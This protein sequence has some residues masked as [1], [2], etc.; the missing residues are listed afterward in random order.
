LATSDGPAWT[1][2]RGAES[3]EQFRGVPQ[4]STALPQRHHGE[5]TPGSDDKDAPP[6]AV[7]WT[8][9]SAVASPRRQGTP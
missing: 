1:R 2:E 7:P 5:A 6:R 4:P 9:T 3:G 8:G